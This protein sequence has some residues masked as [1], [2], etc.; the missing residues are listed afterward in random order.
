MTH[1]LECQ[2]QQV[3]RELWLKVPGRC[4][5]SL[6]GSVWEAFPN[7][8][9]GILCVCVCGRAGCSLLDAGFL[10]F[11]WVGA[12]LHLPCVASLVGEH[13]LPAHG[14]SCLLARGI[15]WEQGSELCPC[16]GRY[17]PLHCTPHQG[18]RLGL[19]S[20]SSLVTYLK[21][22]FPF[23][24][25]HHQ[26]RPLFLFPKYLLNSCGWKPPDAVYSKSR[27]LILVKE[28]QNFSFI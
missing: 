15:L 27:W 18:L 25:L 9:V 8:P 23:W 6:E 22:R 17:V 14:L 1:D 20:A 26:E 21:A 4:H 12:T 16:V 11:R 28:A 13:G 5:L 10:L 7:P 3:W 19:V 2:S 24:H